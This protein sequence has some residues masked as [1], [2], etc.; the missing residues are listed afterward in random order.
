MY[1]GE[2]LR[3][4][5]FFHQIEQDSSFR[6]ATDRVPEVE[7][8]RIRPRLSTGTWQG[9][10]FAK[11]NIRDIVSREIKILSPPRSTDSSF[12]STIERAGI[13]NVCFCFRK[14]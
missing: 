3:G 11:F 9:K 6:G 4:Y 10:N 14:K 2:I 7:V 8:S 5:Q 12:D 1:E 13:Q